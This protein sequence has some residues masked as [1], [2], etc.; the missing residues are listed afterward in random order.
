MKHKKQAATSARLRRGVV[1]LA[2]SAMLVTGTGCT[3]MAVLTPPAAGQPAMPLDANDTAAVR[4]KSG[5]T[6]VLQVTDISVER[7][8]G[9]EAD[10]GRAVSIAVDEIESVE[11]KRLDRARTGLLV[12]GII[13]ALVAL[14]NAV[15]KSI[16]KDVSA[17]YGV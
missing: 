13:L 3:T 11:V 16:Y 17:R 12:L 2:C 14:G 5:V 7:L 1:L 8:S 9:T 10:T 6:R 4:L 15:G